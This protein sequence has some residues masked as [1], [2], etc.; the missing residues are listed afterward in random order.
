[1]SRED[2]FELP[3]SECKKGKYLDTR[4]HAKNKGSSGRNS[5][6]SPTVRSESIRY[7]T[8]TFLGRFLPLRKLVLL[9]MLKTQQFCEALSKGGQNSSMAPASAWDPLPVPREHVL[10]AGIGRRETVS[11][12]REA[13]PSQTE[14]HVAC[15]GCQMV[16]CGAGVPRGLGGRGRGQRMPR[17]GSTPP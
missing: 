8:V 15:F 10:K 13:A 3:G 16:G 4:S 1:M 9:K 12:G 6:G 5:G 7:S 11:V 14:Q 2:P 17:K